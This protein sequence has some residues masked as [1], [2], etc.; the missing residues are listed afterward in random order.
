MVG[1]VTQ[2]SLKVN[3]TFNDLMNALKYFHTC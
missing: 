3:K 1:L 2:D